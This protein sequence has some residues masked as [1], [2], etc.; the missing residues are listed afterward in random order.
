MSSFS[1]LIGLKINHSF[2][3]FDFSLLKSISCKLS[4]NVIQEVYCYMHVGIEVTEVF[5]LATLMHFFPS[6]VCVPVL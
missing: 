6:A 2:Q 3:H 4:K 1:V 5:E